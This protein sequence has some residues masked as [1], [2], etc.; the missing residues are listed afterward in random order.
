MAFYLSLIAA[1][2]L[3][4]A[5]SPQE[6]SHDL[7]VIQVKTILQQSSSELAKFDPIYGLLDADDAFNA[8]KNSKL[9][10]PFLNDACLQQYISD[11][12]ITTV[13]T[14]NLDKNSLSYCLLYRALERNSEFGKP[15]KV[16]SETPKNP[17]IA[18]IK[19]HQ[20]TLLIHY[21]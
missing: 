17:E 3:V 21:N 8:A 7:I 19:Q 10:E 1:A 5:E 12:C 20:G 2:S 6:H 4:L 18:S 11:E 14:K 16:C 9:S 15:S 13:K